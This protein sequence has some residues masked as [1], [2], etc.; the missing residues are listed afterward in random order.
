LTTILHIY[1][2]IG[3]YSENPIEELAVDYVTIEDEDIE[4]T[5]PRNM[6]NIVMYFGDVFGVE[7]AEGLR[8]Y[9]RALLEKG[10]QDLIDIAR[11][12]VYK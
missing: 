8:K 12:V 10:Q 11:N 5:N 9:L 2:S 4:I 3:E 6:L 1:F 7:P